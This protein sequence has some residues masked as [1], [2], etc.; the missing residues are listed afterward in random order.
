MDKIDLLVFESPYGRALTQFDETGHCDFCDFPGAPWY[1]KVAMRGRRLMLGDVKNSV[2]G[3]AWL[4]DV[5]RSGYAVVVVERPQTG[6]SFGSWPD[7]NG[8]VNDLDEHLNWIAAQPWSDGNIGMVGDSINAR[9]QFFA[10]TTGNPLLKAI[11]PATT[12][13]DNYSAVLF[14]GGVPNLAFIRIYPAIQYFFDNMA[15]PVDDDTVGSLLAQARA[16][17]G[18]TPALAAGAESVGRIPF[19]DRMTEDDKMCGAPTW[20][21]IHNW[22]RLIKRVFRST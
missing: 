18:N 3:T 1:Y 14:P 5:L 20:Y 19:R 8:I 2:Q 22:R 15:T 12:W 21:S 13:M 16:E 17:R 9:I 4:G 7:N 6:A 11:L 10:A